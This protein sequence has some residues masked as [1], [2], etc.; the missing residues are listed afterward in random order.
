M[1]GKLVLGL[2]A[3]LVCVIVLIE[4]RLGA[5]Q[6]PGG[7]G[8]KDG[9]KFDPTKWFEKASGGK[10][11]VDISKQYMGKAEMELFA[12]ENGITNGQLTKEQF[13]KYAEQM[14]ELRQKTGNT[15]KGGYGKGQDGKGG[16][17]K[18][19]K[20]PDGK[21]QDNKGEAPKPKITVS[22]EEEVDKKAEEF[23][24]KLDLNGD[25]FLNAEEIAKTRDLKNDWKKW[26]ENKDELISLSEYK[27]Y[28]REFTKRFNER[29]NEN[30]AKRQNRED[31]KSSSTESSGNRKIIIEED[32]E[33]LPIPIRAGGDLPKDFPSWFTEYDTNKDGQVSLYEWRVGKAGREMEL[34]ERMDRNEDGFLTIDE[35]MY[36]NKLTAAQQTAAAKRNTAPNQVTFISGDRPNQPEAGTN[37]NLPGKKGKM[38]KM[39]DGAGKKGKKGG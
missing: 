8:G 15:G 10:D 5:P 12:K 24:T 39:G 32:E 34:F 29:V 25:G 16:Y 9:K 23:F 20:G 3:F 26:D 27:L 17:G 6:P 28:F 18:G 22:T 35:V 14:N 30:E 19:G 36:Y 33:I 11:T 7:K 38:G 2:M 1:R 21:G 37:P 31:A 4:T 13:L